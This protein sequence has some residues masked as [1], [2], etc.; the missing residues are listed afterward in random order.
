MP[1]SPDY[2]DV[3]WMRLDEVETGSYDRRADV[4]LQTALDE[5]TA[6]ATAERMLRKAQA[7]Y[8]RTLVRVRPVCRARARQLRPQRSRQ[9][10]RARR[11]PQP[12][13]TS[14]DPDGDPAPTSIAG[15]LAA[16]VDAIRDM[17]RH[18]LEVQLSK[19]AT[20]LSGFAPI[21]VAEAARR[22]GMSVSY[23]RKRIRDGSLPSTKVGN[24]HRIDPRDLERLRSPS[25]TDRGDDPMATALK[26]LGAR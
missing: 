22:L 25:P 3:R 2:I 6:P 5:T 11:S 1:G 13:A 4:L 24:R 8:E 14:G 15:R 21:D 20:S 16:F 18:E 19:S 10:A 9:R 17:I 12:S 23:I 7:L 26:R